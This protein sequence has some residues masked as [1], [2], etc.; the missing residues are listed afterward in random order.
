MPEKRSVDQSWPAGRPGDQ[1]WSEVRLD[2]KETGSQ[3]WPGKEASDGPGMRQRGQWWPGVRTG[4]KCR[5]RWSTLYSGV[6]YRHYL[7]I[8]YHFSN[9]LSCWICL[10]TVFC[11]NQWR[12]G[13]NVPDPEQWIETRWWS[14]ATNM[15]YHRKQLALVCDGDI[16]FFRS[17]IS[18]TLLDLG[19][20]FLCSGHYYVLACGWA[21][22]RNSRLSWTEHC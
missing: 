15:N 6:W 13:T 9:V 8:F 14:L 18:L 7:S 19:H 2:N 1:Y 12:D 3:S 21:N 20:Y 16:L 5:R 11:L 17:T 10:H 4:G 22:L